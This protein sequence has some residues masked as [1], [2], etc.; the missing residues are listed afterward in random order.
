MTVKVAYT[1]TATA[2]GGRDGSARTSEAW[3]KAAL[4]ARKAAA[5]RTR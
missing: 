4:V 3:A 2:T 5:G 1:T